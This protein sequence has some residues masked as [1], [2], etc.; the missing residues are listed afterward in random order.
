[1]KRHSDL[2]Q[3]KTEACSLSR[4]TAFNKHTIAAFFEKLLNVYDRNVEFTNG[5]RLFNL[6]ETSTSTEQKPKNVVSLKAKSKF[7]K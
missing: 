2:S 1:M 3:K 4:A 7:H 6:D 5:T